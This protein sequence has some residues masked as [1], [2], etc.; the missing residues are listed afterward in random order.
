MLSM[1][2]TRNDFAAV[3]TGM[4]VAALARLAGLG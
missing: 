2:V 3:I 1:W 4:G